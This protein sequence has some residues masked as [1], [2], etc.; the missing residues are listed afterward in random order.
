MATQVRFVILAADKLEQLWPVSTPERSF[1]L[2]SGP[3]GKSPFAKLLTAT[4]DADAEADVM[5]IAATH[6]LDDVMRALHDSPWQ[7]W[8]LV[9]VDPTCAS[10]VLIVLAG[11]IAARENRNRRIVFL[12]ANLLASTHMKLADTIKT[13]SL[14]DPLAPDAT[15]IAG[16]VINGALTTDTATSGTRLLVDRLPRP[17]WHKLHGLANSADANN[18]TEAVEI[19]ATGFMSTRPGPL[20]DLVHRTAPIIVQACSNALALARS[21]GN[22]VLFPQNSFLTLA[23]DLDFAHMFANH[24]FR[25][26]ARLLDE[27]VSVARSWDDRLARD[28]APQD[29]AAGLQLGGFSAASVIQF[30]GRTLVLEPGHASEVAF[31]TRRAGTEPSDNSVIA[32]VRYDTLACGRE[33]DLWRLCLPVGTQ[34]QPE[35]HFTREEHLLVVE[36]TVSV[37][38]D[39]I[40]QNARPGDHICIE[41]GALHAIENIG[42][43]TACVIEARYGEIRDE[44]DRVTIPDGFNTTKLGA[45]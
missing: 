42:V 21:S 14:G 37:T 40:S 13:M 1:A 20:I 11:L 36:G 32:A 22:G 39:G 44:G 15:C 28:N 31:P 19:A 30:A 8:G 45:A 4:H 9:S 35:C 33:A 3:D 12:P 18:G 43:G 26:R 16:Q 6:A 7:Q 27:Q 24:P 38:V 41:R 17:G 29:V 25:A 10:G 5:V 34:T 23:G 2:V